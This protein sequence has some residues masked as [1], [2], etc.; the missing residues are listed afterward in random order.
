MKRKI[1][2]VAAM[3]LVMV[4]F[5]VTTL[6]A[7]GSAQ[8]G[9]SP[10]SGKKLVVGTMARALGLPVR[11]AQEKGF[12]REEGVE[13]EIVLFATGAPINEA[14]AAEKI[15]VAVSGMASVYALATGRYTY[16]GDTAIS[17]LGQAIYVRPDSPIAKVNGIIPGT[18]GSAATV[19]GISILGPLATSAHYNA[20]KY[21]ESF[22]LTTDDF[23]M[24]SMEY[25]QAYQAFIT[26]QG[27]AIT[28][29]PP[30]SFQLEDAGYMKVAELANTSGAP[31]TDGIYIQ[32]NV[33]AS[34]KADV[35]AFLKA[36]YR[37]TEALMKD[38]R[39]RSQVAMAWYAEE[40]IKYSDSDMAAEI[41]AQSY[42]TV[43]I[44]SAS[45]YLFGATMINIGSFFTLQG[46]IEK[47]NLPNIGASMD[48][49]FV[50]QIIGK[51]VTVPK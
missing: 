8:K 36:Y 50:E 7:G 28:T 10:E 21:V 49:S 18:K 22:G 47:V 29:T 14:M 27:D 1:M 9:Q 38:P 23:K 24:V 31:L 32:K 35:L 51:K 2:L 33:V 39:A 30:Y 20:I 37:A 11:Y 5:P 48:P 15:E 40:G 6:F 43:P 3:V 12:F 41:K 19:K 26:G 42:T 46:M 25:A 45:E 17:F 13:V 16:V 44:M 4:L 34:R